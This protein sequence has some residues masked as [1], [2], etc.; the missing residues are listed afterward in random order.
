M[1]TTISPLRQSKLTTN[2][3]VILVPIS[4]APLLCV[5]YLQWWQNISDKN[6][7]YVRRRFLRQAGTGRGCAP[8]SSDV[9]KYSWPSSLPL[10]RSLHPRLPRSPWPAFLFALLFSHDLPF[11]PWTRIRTSGSAPVTFK[12]IPQHMYQL[13]RAGIVPRVRF[14]LA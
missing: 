14:P 1:T 4:P 12:C 10:L 9:G 13:I 5:V 6:G 7:D 11:L 2:S 3:G 8:W